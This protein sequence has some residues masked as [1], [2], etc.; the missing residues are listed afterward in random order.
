MAG[1]NALGDDGAAGVLADVDHLGAG[2]GLLPVA[3]QGHRVKLAHR[4]FAAQH[5]AWILPSDGRTGLD[6]GPG[7]LGVAALAQAALGHEVVDTALALGIAR[8]PVLH[9]G[10]FDGGVVQRHQF[11]HRRMQLVFVALRRG[12]AF[13]V[14]DV[15]PLVGNDQRP[16]ELAGVAGVDAEVGGQFH[17]AAHARRDVD[18]GTVGKH[19][20]IQ[21]RVVVVPIRHHRAQILAHQLGMLAHRLG[22]R[23]EHDA[24][25]GQLALVA[26]RHRHRIEHRV[27]RHAG[28]DGLFRQRNT[29]LFVG[30][31]Q[32]RINFIQT[33]RAVGFLL[34][35]GI[36]GK[37]L[38]VDGWIVNPRPLGLF[39]GQPMTIS[40]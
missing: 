37:R 30:T 23:A 8:I 24:Q 22:E 35:R 2:V 31:K 17:R 29:K 11:H 14:G 38:I 20:R 32:L 19:R 36:V 3:G 18:E 5:A 33:F 6:L 34:G 10:V 40:L 4:V 27:H 16:F 21:R 9:R 12:T 39:L 1:G 28:Q 15:S 13:Q 26:G 25:F 7:D